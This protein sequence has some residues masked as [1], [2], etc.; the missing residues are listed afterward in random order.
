MK[1]FK[2]DNVIKKTDNKVKIKKLLQQGFVEVNEKGE[3]VKEQLPKDSDEL[4]EELKHSKV[5]IKELEAEIEKANANVGTDVE[6]E[7]KAK[8]EAAKK[9]KE[10]EAAKKAETKKG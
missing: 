9:A 5:R 6:T 2:L 4:S 3:V 10:E 7:K 1:Q 8:E